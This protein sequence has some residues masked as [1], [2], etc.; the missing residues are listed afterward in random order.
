[1]KNLSY[2]SITA[3]LYDVLVPRDIEGIC[4]SVSR[5]LARHTE[6]REILDLGCG[7]GR[8]T[9]ALAKRGFRVMGMDITPEMLAV[10][11]TNAKS[12]GVKVRLTTGDMRNFRLAKR[13]GIIWARGSIGDLIEMDD[14]RKTFVNVES[15]L[16]DEGIFILDVRD[17]SFYLQKFSDGSRKEE[18]VFKHGNRV[19]TFNFS[20]RLDKRTGIETMEGEI[21]VDEGGSMRRYEVNHALRYYTRREVTKLLK[22]TGL[23]ILQMNNGYELDSAKKPQLVIVAQR[24]S[25]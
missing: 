17:R 15:N 21:G 18:K 4:N 16:E 23:K 10:A 13:I 8:F 2:Y 9:I 12:A 1:M 3:E 14:V 11:R 19:I 6:C 7:T 20:A 5:I 24:E 25:C 22:E